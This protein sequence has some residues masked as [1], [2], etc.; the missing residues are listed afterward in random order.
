[1]S[2]RVV[3]ETVRGETHV[4]TVEGRNYDVE[5]DS[6]G[7][8]LVN[9]KVADFGLTSMGFERGYWVSYRIEDVDDVSAH[10]GALHDH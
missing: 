1:M 8:L 7:R 3:V 9:Q 4:L 2:Y 5:I 6:D 10:L